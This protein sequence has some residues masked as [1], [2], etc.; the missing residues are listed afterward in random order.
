MYVEYSGKRFF[1]VSD[2]GD[3]IPL[4]LQPNMSESIGDNAGDAEAFMKNQTGSGMD[5]NAILKSFEMTDVDVGHDCVVLFIWFAIAHMIS[6]IYLCW[7]HY[8][9]RRTFVYSDKE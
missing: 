3:L 5:G 1:N 4:D 8:K 6:I 7:N 2:V 9:S